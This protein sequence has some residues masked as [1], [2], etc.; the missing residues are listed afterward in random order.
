MKFTMIDE[1]IS[2]ALKNTLARADRAKRKRF[3]AEVAP[4]K[5]KLDKVKSDSAIYKK[6][7]KKIEKIERD[8]G[9][10]Y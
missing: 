1:S 8:Y 7:Q 10:R 4:L 9:Y 2:R 6:I 5:Q 3:D